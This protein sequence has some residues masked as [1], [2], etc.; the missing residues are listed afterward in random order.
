[1]ISATQRA[2]I[3]TFIIF[4]GSL[5]LFTVGLCHQEVIEFESRFYLFALEM[6]RHGLSWFPMSDGHPYP[7][8]PVT[9]TVLIYGM[10][11]LTGQL[12]KLI[13]VL[14]S[15]MAASF[16]LVG[17]YL[18]GALRHR[19]WGW[20]AVFF[21]LLTNGFVMEARTISTDQYVTLVTVWCFYLSYSALLLQKFHRLR[22]MP[23][24]FLIGFAFRG[25][26]G[27]VIPAAVVCL[28]Y[29]LE[30]DVK[31]FFITGCVAAILLGIGSGFLLALAYHVGGMGFVKEVLR[32]EVAA[33]LHE[34]GLPWYFYFVESV[35]AYAV[36][37][38]LAILVVLGFS[39]QL[40]KSNVSVDLKL[41]QKLSAWVLVILIGLSFPAGKKIRYVLAM[42]PALALISAY[43]FMWQAQ[44][45][46]LAY[47]QRFVYGICY[48]LPLFCA[49]VL[50]VLKL[51]VS[52]ALVEIP[53]ALWLLFLALQIIVWVG[54]QRFAHA[55]KL[56]VLAV[57]ALT[58]VL[59]YQLMVEPIHLML[60]Q[61]RDFVNAVELLRHQHHAKLVFYRENPDGLPIKYLADMTQED[62]PFF[63]NSPDELLHFKPHAFFVIKKEGYAGL[64]PSVTSV[65]H[66]VEKGNIGR[67]PMIVLE[68]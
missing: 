62:S 39:R 27:L 17:T 29:L 36:T 25:P 26:I 10:T 23:L 45:G 13:A 37:Y 4:C 66:V 33:R 12:N 38:P 2:T 56:I 46:Y 31:R 63:V 44:R 59:S 60:N 58:F 49:A 35:G 61:T 40:I 24:L 47:L 11:K 41:L 22:W 42:T 64:P 3:D 65:F 54:S 18:I 6:W 9:S 43:L 8:Y 14:P 19:L 5:I 15:A 21:M 68:N 50:I 1:M 67:E 28:F 20:Y 32:M 7:D 48:W 34:G 30:K 57:A 51:K 53:N 52:Q 55:Q 16:V